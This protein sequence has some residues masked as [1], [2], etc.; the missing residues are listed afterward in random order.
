M[1]R[2]QARRAPSLDC[3]EDASFVGLVV[4]TVEYSEVPAV[5]IYDASNDGTFWCRRAGFARSI[6]D[7]DTFTPKVRA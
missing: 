1:A 6:A 7:D 2:M 4:P 3:D 5:R